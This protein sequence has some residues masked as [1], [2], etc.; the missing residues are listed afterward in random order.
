MK[1]LIGGMALLAVMGVWA[2][3]AMA[4]LSN[5]PV[6]TSP[7]GYMGV[8]ISADWGMGLNDDSKWEDSSPM[9]F[10]GMLG[11]GTGMFNINAGAAYVDPKAETLGLKKPISFGGNIGVTV[12]PSTEQSPLAVNVFAGAGY[13]NYKAEV[14][15]GGDADVLKQLD[16]PFGV[17]IGFSPPTSGSVGFEIWAAPRGVYSSQDFGTKFNRFGFGASGGVNVNF[18]AGFGIHATMDWSTFS[19]KTVDQEI[20]PKYSPLYLGAGLHYTFRTPS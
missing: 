14:G 9:A 11:F 10:G 20:A 4:Q 13:T 16:I 12:L 2:A 3:P 5:M 17:G 15:T 18:D 7:A 8:R 1:K 19:E 6:W